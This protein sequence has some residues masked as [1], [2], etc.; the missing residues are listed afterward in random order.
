MN[1]QTQN[2]LVAI[3]WF[4]FFTAICTIIIYGNKKCP[5][6]NRSACIPFS[7]PEPVDD[8]PDEAPIEKSKWI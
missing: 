2:D 6:E 3:A 8:T 7:A 4:V 5:R 1:R